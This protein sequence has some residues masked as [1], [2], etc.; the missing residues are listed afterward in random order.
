MANILLQLARKLSEEIGCITNQEDDDFD[1]EWAITHRLL[2]INMN[3]LVQ[4]GNIPPHLLP[5]TTFKTASAYFLALADW[6][7]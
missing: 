4:L 5:Q 1:D 2:T 7:S 3:E 6:A